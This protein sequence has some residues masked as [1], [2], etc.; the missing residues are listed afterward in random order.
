MW[1]YARE[2]AKES[3]EAWAAADEI[4][5]GLEVLTDSPQRLGDGGGYI[6]RRIPMEPQRGWED[7]LVAAGS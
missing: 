2:T 6:K 1:G 4:Y 5:L 3:T 7:I